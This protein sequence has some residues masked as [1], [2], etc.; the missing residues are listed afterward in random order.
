MREARLLNSTRDALGFTNFRYQQTI[1]GIPV[2]NAVY[3]VHVKGGKVLSE[4]GKWVKDAPRVLA[5]GASLK[6]AV[7]LKSALQSVNA[8]VYRWQNAEEEALLKQE[9]EN[10]SATYFPKASL[11]II[12]VKMK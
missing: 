8:K 6:E 10:L 1:N 4:N 2:E 7:A 11:F 5:A 3:N 12:P 9:T